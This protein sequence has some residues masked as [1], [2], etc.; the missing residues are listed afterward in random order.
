MDSLPLTEVSYYFYILKRNV[1]NIYIYTNFFE[2]I[3]VQSP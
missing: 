2:Y 1:P 3:D